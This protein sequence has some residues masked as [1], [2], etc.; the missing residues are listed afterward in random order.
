[1]FL[2]IERK[3]VITVAAEEALFDADGEVVREGVVEES[4][5]VCGTVYF[6]DSAATV[7]QNMANGV[8]IDYYAI[9]VDE[10]TFAPT[11]KK[12]REKARA[13]APAYEEVTIET[14]DGAELGSAIV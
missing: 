10:D 1:M 2:A 14:E 4:H 6:E 5:E 9:E 3:K 12:V 11:I 8:R 13:P 7:A